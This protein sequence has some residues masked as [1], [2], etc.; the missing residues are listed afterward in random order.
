MIKKRIAVAIA[1]SVFSGWCAAQASSDQ[2]PDRQGDASQDRPVAFH[3]AGYV[4][5]AY[6][7]S[8][9][10]DGSKAFGTLA[11][12]LHLQVG[13]RFLVETDSNW[14]RTATANWRKASNTPRSAI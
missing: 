4:D 1:L 2:D 6:A 14:M 9:R 5:V 11:P 3:L 8:D 13:D 12:I 10:P 7:A